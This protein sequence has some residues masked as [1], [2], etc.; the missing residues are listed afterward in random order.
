MLPVSELQYSLADLD[1]IYRDPQESLLLNIEPQQ[2][3]E[4]GMVE[5]HE[6]LDHSIFDSGVPR[7][8]NILDSDDSKDFL[9]ETPPPAGLITDMDPQDMDVDPDVSD[10]LDP[11]LDIKPPEPDFDTD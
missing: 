2:I 5:S 7:N 11:L 6:A 9:G 4:Q 1:A 3:L 10:Q 8:N